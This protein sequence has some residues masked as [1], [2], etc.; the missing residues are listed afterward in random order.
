MRQLALLLTLLATSRLNA[1][2]GGVLG[3]WQDPSHSVIEIT[4]CG[5]KVC[6]SAL[7][8]SAICGSAITSTSPIPPTLKTASSTTPRPAIPTAAS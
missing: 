6:A 4:R 7:A 3:R 5:D 1:Q 8:R 2:T